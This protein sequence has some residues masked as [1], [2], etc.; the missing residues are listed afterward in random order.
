MGIMTTP[1]EP[2]WDRHAI[3]AAIERK[4]LSLTDIAKS[5]GM[6]AQ[7]VRN[8]LDKPSLSGEIAIAKSLGIE[9][10]VLFPD[11]WTADGKRIYP[12]YNKTARS[13]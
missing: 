3:K 1:K 4:G 9:V 2:I 12:R 13:A 5:Y 10:Q 11:R 6:P 8:A 7:T